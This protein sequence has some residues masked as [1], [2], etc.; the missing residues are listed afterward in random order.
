MTATDLPLWLAGI[1]LHLNLP[2]RSN[3][4][5]T[6]RGNDTRLPGSSLATTLLWGALVVS[7][8]CL[9]QNLAVTDS[10]ASLQHLLPGS[11]ASK[12]ILT[13]DAAAAMS[14]GLAT[15]IGV[16]SQF[17]AGLQPILNYSRFKVVPGQ[18]SPTTNRYIVELENAGLGPAIVT[19]VGY[20]LEV[21][22]SCEAHADVSSLRNRLAELGLNQDECDVTGIVEGYAIP[23]D[24]RIVMAEL[25]RSCADH[26]VQLTIHMNFR[27]VFGGRYVQ[28][29][30]CL[31]PP[32]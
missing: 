15:V 22:N 17:R 29:I 18:N 10:V 5:V 2:V 25:S 16:R 24:S 23:K 32:L 19:H 8:F 11:L 27:S 28:V 31:P 14:I 3:H 26:I 4:R 1:L 30:C 12:P 20:T 6:R 7:G 21:A 13:T 9:I